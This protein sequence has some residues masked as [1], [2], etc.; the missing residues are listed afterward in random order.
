LKKNDVYIILIAAAFFYFL[1][2]TKKADEK[3]IFIK[4]LP[5]VAGITE[6]TF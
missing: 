5:K 3:Q 6:T 2:K 4:E 1:N